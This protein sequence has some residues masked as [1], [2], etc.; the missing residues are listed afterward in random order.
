MLH[1]YGMF[2]LALNIGLHN[3]MAAVLCQDWPSVGIWIACDF[4][5]ILWRTQR[6]E[7]GLHFVLV[8]IPTEGIA[9]DWFD[10][11]LFCVNVMYICI[12]VNLMFSRCLDPG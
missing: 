12:Y 5:V 3:S 11:G 6:P 7:W 2:P 9:V 10:E 8:D 4:L 1:I